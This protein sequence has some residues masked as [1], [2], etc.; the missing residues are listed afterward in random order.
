MITTDVIDHV[1]S[2]IDGRCCCG[3][4]GTHY[5]ASAG[6]VEEYTSEKVSD[7]MVSKV[8]RIVNEAIGAG[9][10]QLGVHHISTVRGRRLYIVY[11]RDGVSARKVFES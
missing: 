2:G 7:R 5:V 6:A 10:A 4:S 9:T 11:L 8:A 3:C 1:Y